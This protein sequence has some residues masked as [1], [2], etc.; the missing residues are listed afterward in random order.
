MRITEMKPSARRKG[1]WLVRLE[2]G[3]LL[4]VNEGT[5]ADFS[6]YCGMEL[7]DETRARLETAAR[8]GS[9]RD[10]AV[11]LL[12][13]RPMSRAELLKKLAER[14]AE[15][16]EAADVADWL[17]RLGL[18]DDA[19][20]AQ[21]LV[22]HYGAKGYGPYRLREELYR[23][24]VPRELWESAMALCGDP[25]EQIDAFLESRLRGGR[26]DRKELKRVSDALARR[27]FRWGD[28]KAG[29]C[30]YGADGEY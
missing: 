24:G 12:T 2:D 15:T 10:K 8:R 13:A 6:L 5:V 27:G 7:T 11:S 14:G 18:L 1:R 21:T 16:E 9:W 28:I 29:L 23:R 20:Y 17:E 26:P 4:R 22:R 19:G 25:A 30:R 3:T